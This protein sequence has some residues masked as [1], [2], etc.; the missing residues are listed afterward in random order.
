MR[1]YSEAVR[2][3]VRRRMS[4][5]HRQSVARISAEL[6]I[7]VV[8]LYNWRKTWRLQGEV[9]PAS[10]KDPEGWGA[11]DKFTVVLETAGLNAT[12]LSAYCRERGLYPEQV[13]RWRQ[14]SQ[15]ANEKPVLTLKEQKELERLRAQDQ[16][17]I[18]PLKQELRRK[19]KALAEAAA[20]LIASKKIQAFWGEDGDD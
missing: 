5:P 19:E 13:E 15:D 9:V 18:K 3:D 16:K 1:R 12:E 14:A 7:H 2:A 8:T 17:E 4:P 20:L 11:T 6:G 10:E